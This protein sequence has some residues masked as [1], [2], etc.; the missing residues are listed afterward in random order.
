MGCASLKKERTPFDGT[1]LLIQSSGGFI[2]KTQLPEKETLLLLQN[3]KMTRI[4]E[5]NI[6]SEDVFKVEKGKVIESK[7]PQYILISGKQ[8]KQSV[9]IKNDTLILRDQC[10]D[11]F[12]YRYK[13]VK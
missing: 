1:W 6:I 7:Q 9:T 3:G 4:E 13:K 11:C 12:T 8:L 5:G 10:Y 2:G